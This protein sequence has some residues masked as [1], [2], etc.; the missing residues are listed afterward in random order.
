MVQPFEDVANDV[1]ICALV[2]IVNILGA[3]TGIGAGAVVTPLL[4][5]IL[6]LDIK[7]AIPISVFIILITGI[8]K[9]L[10]FSSKRHP[11]TDLRHAISLMPLL[12]LIPSIS[13][14]SYVGTVLAIMFPDPLIAFL[15]TIIFGY[16]AY[17]AIRK[18]IIMYRK[19][20]NEKLEKLAMKE[21][22]ILD[23]NLD[24]HD[25]VS[26]NSITSH[27]GIDETGDT[28]RSMAKSTVFIFITITIVGVSTL[29]RTFIDKCSS[30]YYVELGGQM[31]IIFLLILTV[32]KYIL[33]K[34]DRLNK[35]NYKRVSGDI[36]WNSIILARFN[37]I[38]MLIG[39]AT[40]LMSIGGAM[41]LNP[42][43]A[44]YNMVPYA[45]VA[46]ASVSTTLSALVSTINYAALSMIHWNYSLLLAACGATGTLIGLWFLEKIKNHRQSYIMILLSFMIIGSIIIM[47]ATIVHNGDMSFTFDKYC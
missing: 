14:T 30:G 19:E 27:N 23:D 13:L 34:Q 10:Y 11:E 36:E 38:G 8:T 15:I 31:L 35:R 3:C 44:S 1:I 32:D 28:L 47:V 39:I 46:T 33:N 22:K 26:T 40:S 4:T 43:L 9:V 18:G 16:S 41:I 42:M 17:K 12:S 24:M 21:I 37:A 29:A 5:F 20:S 2:F 6:G 7:E 45:I 25:T